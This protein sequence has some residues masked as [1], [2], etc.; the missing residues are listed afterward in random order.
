MRVPRLLLVTAVVVALAPA[1]SLGQEDQRRYAVEVVLFRQAEIGG[2]SEWWPRHAPS[3][4][5]ERIGALAADDVRT[6]PGGELELTRFRNGLAAAPGYEVLG[7]FGWV[8]PDWSEQEAAAVALPLGWTPPTS[9][10][11]PFAFVPAGTRLFGTVKVY[12]SRYLHVQTD[13]RFYPQG[14][15]ATP[16]L[17]PVPGADPLTGLETTVPEEPAGPRVYPMVQ[18]Q[19]MRSGDI[20]YLDH[21]VLGILIEVRSLQ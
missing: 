6:L 1:A 2:G 14:R 10:A 20:H 16:P 9:V 18:S 12:V 4:G 8:Q 11:D 5:P 13:L 15:P 3:P 7:H 19:R 17:R 21:P